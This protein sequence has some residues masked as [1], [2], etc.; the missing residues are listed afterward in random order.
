MTSM[1]FAT[2]LAAGIFS[3]VFIGLGGEERVA[4]ILAQMPA[5]PTGALVFCMIFI[6]VLGFFL[7]FVEISVIVLPLI[8]PTLI[9][10]GHDPIWL[11]ILIAINLQTSF[12]TPPFGFSLFYLRGAA[13]DEVTTMHIYRGV[14]PFIGLQ[15]IGVILVWSLPVLATWLPRALF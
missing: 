14:V 6:F 12:L 7:D 4:A 3:L 1:I 9:V 8:T 15:A 5:G 11:G 13:P 10:M 2:I